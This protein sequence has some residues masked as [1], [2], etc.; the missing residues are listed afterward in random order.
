MKN[1]RHPPH[2]TAAILILCL[3]QFVDVLGV[4]ELIAAMPPALRGLRAAPSAAGL[5]LTAYA[6]CFGGLLMLGARLGDRYGQRRTLG[7]GLGLF[8]AGSL[9]AAVAGSAGALVAGRA[10]QGA[11]A[12]VSVPAALRLL[13]QVAPAGA[14][15][16]RAL[17]GWSAAG[18]AAG[19]GGYLLG[20]GLTA[21]AGWRAMFW[22][23]L[24]LAAGL[25]LAVGRCVPGDARRSRSR[26]RLD[27]AGGGLLTAAVMAVVL[28][29]SLAQTP[30]RGVIALLVLAG[31]GVLLAGL[32]VRLRRA[33]DPVVA[34]AALRD[35]RLR[36]GAAAAFANT[37]T[38]SPAIAI[39]TLALQRREHLGAGAA[40]LR[41][42]PFSLGALAGSAA[43]VVM[44][45]HR[46]RPATIAAGLTM[47]G[48]GDALLC[49]FLGSDL[50]LL[51]AVS[52]AGAGI[53]LSSVAATGLG[54]DVAAGLEA[55]AGA[56]VNTAAQLGTALGVA[57]ILLVTALSARAGLP[58]GGPRLGWATEATIAV[59]AAA[60]ALAGQRR[61]RP[62]GATVAVSPRRRV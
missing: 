33:A 17:A 51:A 21:V 15:A 55:A 49:A 38:T 18:A 58:L 30:G 23:N 48:A 52:V 36:A 39:A 5:I 4:T 57:V 1:A 43:A 14:T 10:V 60:A 37:A 62:A 16:R 46:S 50:A 26:S 25:A 31:A 40:A 20:G 35:R 42:M 44:L 34:P 6:M 9:I 22:V 8:A 3:V 32:V 11:A 59:G 12:A 45:R 29:A 13:R 47:I 41:L 61:R 28:A 24:P 56:V 7:A 2:L 27:V 53:G 54:T 19:A